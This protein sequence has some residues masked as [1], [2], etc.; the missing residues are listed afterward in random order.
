MI[1]P[2]VGGRRH[3]WPVVVARA[4]TD[5][6]LLRWQTPTAATLSCRG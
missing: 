6:E 4:R 1:G 2:A 5:P 3:E